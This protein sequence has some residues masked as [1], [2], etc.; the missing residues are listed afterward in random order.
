MT[1]CRRAAALLRHLLVAA[2]LLAVAASSPAAE[3][4]KALKLIGSG[5]S[6]PAPLYLRWFRDYYV[7]HPELQVDYQST[8]SAGGV[9]DLIG[10]RVDFAGTDLPLTEEQARR[11]AGG[12]RQAPMA[13]GGIVAVYSLDGVPDLKLS[14]DAL[15]G[16][17]SGRIAR[18]NDAAIAAANPGATLPDAPITVVARADSSGTTYKFTRHLSAVSAEFAQ[19]VGTNMLPNWPKAL[20]VRGGLVRG[21]GND[22][23]AAS[24]RAIPGSIGYV[25]YAFGF[26]PGISMAA[27]ENRSGK[28]VAP[29]E[30][31]FDAAML[32]VY[33]NHSVENTSD[34]IGDGAYPIVG[35]SWLVL[36]NRY[37]DPAKPAAL[38]DVIAYALGAGQDIT[39]RLGYVRFPKPLITSVQEQL[40]K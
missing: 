35:I 38:D 25:Q 34:P 5:A 21:R 40:I 32:S 6:F 3:Q 39:E 9:Q 1:H 2:S 10:G 18:W 4:G 24:V 16:I 17:F 12:I 29:G 37:D 14:R 27:L 22:G 26:L 23:V 13:A 19:Q 28:Y 33:E 7:A 20:K 15:V 8:G 31:G 36:R 30:A 11:V